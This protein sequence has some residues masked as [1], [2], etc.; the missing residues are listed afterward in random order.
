MH[1]EA[2]GGIRSLPEDLQATII[3]H[4]RGHPS[5]SRS[6][7][8]AF[9]GVFST[10]HLCVLWALEGMSGDHVAAYDWLARHKSRMQPPASIHTC[11]T[12]LARGAPAHAL[13]LLL[14]RAVEVLLQNGADVQ[15]GS[16][17]AAALGAVEALVAAGADTETRDKVRGHAELHFNAW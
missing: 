15:G 14:S 1:E 12:Q 11:T 10:P 7:Y 9:L 16:Q 3:L 4:S 17:R 8:S 13:D 2:A 6:F 5:V